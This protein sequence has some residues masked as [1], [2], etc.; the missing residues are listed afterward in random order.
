MIE[1]WAQEG[2]SAAK[3]KN[4]VRRGSGG[5]ISE[6]NLQLIKVQAVNNLHLYML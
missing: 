3:V 5:G 6:R 2:A 4:F 1:I